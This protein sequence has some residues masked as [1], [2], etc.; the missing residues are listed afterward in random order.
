MEIILSLVIF[1]LCALGL[2]LGAIF[3]RGPLKGSCGGIGSA[4][5][6]CSATAESCDIEQKTADTLSYNA[7][8]H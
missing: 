5:C 6:S 8:K 3:K 7:A 2:S 1:L 4:D